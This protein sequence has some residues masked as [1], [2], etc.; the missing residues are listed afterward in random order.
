[1]DAYYYSTVYKSY[2]HSKSYVTIVHLLAILVL[3]TYTKSNFAYLLE[4]D[5]SMYYFTWPS[6]GNLMGLYGAQ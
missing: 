3:R 1:M 5:F 2:T 4:I 6:L